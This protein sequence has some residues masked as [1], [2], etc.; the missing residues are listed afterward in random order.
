MKRRRFQRREASLE[1]VDVNQTQS[2]ITSTR[3]E[4]VKEPYKRLGIF[5]TGD[6]SNQFRRGA[7]R[8]IGFEERST[9]DLTAHQADWCVRHRRA[10]T[11]RDFDEGVVVVK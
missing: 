9:S 8:Q 4:R 5:P 2:K 7:V 11:L 10:W 1:I 6:D 3:R